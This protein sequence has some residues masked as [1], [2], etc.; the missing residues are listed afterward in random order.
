PDIPA[1]G[2]STISFQATVNSAPSD[3]SSKYVNNATINYTFKTPDSSSLTNSVTTTNTIYPS[4]VVITPDVTKTDKTSNSVNHFVAVN[5]TVTYTITIE[6]TDRNNPISNII[7]KD[8]LPQGLSF[9]AGTVIIDNVNKPQDDPTA[10]S[11]I[12]IPDISASNTST[13]SFEATV[14]ALPSNGSSKYVNNATIDYTFKTPDS[15]LLTNSVTAT[16]T[17]YPNVV[18]ITPNVTKT[19]KT[20]NA[21]NHIVALHDTVIYTITIE[22]TDHNNPL[23]NITLKDTLPKGLSFNSGTVFINNVNKPQDD[24]TNISGIT[25]PDISANGTSTI[26]F[27]ATVNALPSN[28]SSNYVN[29]A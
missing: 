7:L 12:T 4:S 6:N 15:K 27:E 25:V 3:G 18:I 26:S 24:P 8:T 22:N 14:N 16:D 5:D 21:V 10:S 28:G 19:D 9:K 29:N 11:G 17:I 1:N 23:T 2:T 13:I 20:S